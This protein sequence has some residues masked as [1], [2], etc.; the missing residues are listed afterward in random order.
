M[1]I[2]CTLSRQALT[3]SCAETVHFAGP[4][5]KQRTCYVNVGQAPLRIWRSYNEGSYPKLTDFSVFEGRRIRFGSY[6]D[7]VFIP[8]DVLKAIA[9]H[10]AGWTGYTHQWRNPLFAAY[11]EFIMAS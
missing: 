2:H 6:G 4:N 7:P 11:R 3:M 10:S 8:F 9:H 1:R 5:G